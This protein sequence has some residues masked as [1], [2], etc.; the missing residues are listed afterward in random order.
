MRRNLA[1]ALGLA[2]CAA[3]ELTHAA[4]DMTPYNPKERRGPKSSTRE[5]VC[6]NGIWKF[7]PVIEE[8][9]YTC[10]EFPDP[11][12]PPASLKYV[13]L[14][15]PGLWKDRGN[16]FSGCRLPD[17]K[18]LPVEWRKAL[19]AWYHRVFQVP[20][21]WAGRAVIIRFEGIAFYG[22]VFV[23]GKAVGEHLGPGT[24]FELDISALV[25]PGKPNNL[26]VY[27]IDKRKGLHVPKGLSGY[28]SWGVQLW[29]ILPEQWEYRRD[30]AGIWKDVF[31][32]ARDPLFV[33][34]VFAMPSFRK[35][36][37]AG[38]IEV[39]NHG[40]RPC[41]CRV[42]VD[43]LELDGTPV[44]EV[45]S[46]DITVLPG[47]AEVSTLSAPWATPKLWDLDEPNLYVMRARLQDYGPRRN[48]ID[49]KLVRFGFRECWVEKDQIYLNGRIFHPLGDWDTR[50]NVTSPMIA[51][52][53][54]VAL[55]KLESM[56]EDAGFVAPRMT[57]IT[58]Y[59]D[60]YDAADDLGFPIIA[61]GYAGSRIDPVAWDG[62][63]QEWREAIRMR[64]NH[65]SIIIWSCENEGVSHSRA[66]SLY[67]IQRKL[68][69]ILEEMDP[70]RP[71]YHD[72]H[73]SVV[74]GDPGAIYEN[75]D[76]CGTAPIS[77]G[78]YT[79]ATSPMSLW[80]HEFDRWRRRKP[81]V[82]GEAGTFGL[83]DI[84]AYI[85]R[86]YGEEA[87]GQP[88]EEVFDELGGK[89]TK[90][91]IG[92]W[93]SYAVS[94][95]MPLGVYQSYRGIYRHSGR[96]T[97]LKW[98]DL[99]TPGAKPFTTSF[100]LARN[101]YD[102][103]GGSVKVSRYGEWV[104]D[105]FA[106]LL[107][108]LYRDLRHNLRSGEAT[109]AAVYVVN[110]AKTDQTVQLAWSVA[111]VAGGDALAKGE[112]SLLVRQG[113]PAR[114]ELRF[115]AP[116]VKAATRL[117]L[118]VEARADGVTHVAKDDREFSVYPVDPA[119]KLT[120]TLYAYDPENRLTDL[121]ASMKLTAA[122]LSAATFAGA[123][124][125]K[126][127]IIAPY[128]VDKD[129]RPHYGDIDKFL[130]AGG[131]V[132]VLNQ[133]C[134]LPSS[135]SS[136]MHSGSQ[137]HPMFRGL[138]DSRVYFW[139]T[140]GNLVAG[141]GIKLP[142]HGLYVRHLTET[143]HTSLKDPFLFE[144]FKGNGTLVGCNLLLAGAYEKDPEARLMLHNLLRYA[145]GFRRQPRPV[146]FSGTADTASAI[147]KLGVRLTGLALQVAN[148]GQ[149]AVLAGLGATLSKQ[150]IADAAKL[151]SGILLVERTDLVA[152]NRDAV[153]AF[154]A[155]GGA[156]L[157]LAQ[158]DA[159]WQGWGDDAKLALAPAGR[160]ARGGHLHK[161]SDAPMLAGQRSVTAWSE[162]VL[163]LKPSTGWS[164]DF[165]AVG[166]EGPMDRFG[167]AWREQGQGLVIVDQVPHLPVKLRY[168]TNAQGQWLLLTLL[169]N[170]GA[171]LVQPAP[172]EY[173]T[174]FT[175]VKE[176][177]A[178]V[179]ALTEEEKKRFHFLNLKFHMNAC[180]GGEKHSHDVCNAIY[181]KVPLGA[182][183]FGGVP[184]YVVDAD[185]DELLGGDPGATDSCI[186]LRG[187]KMPAL[188][189]ETRE[190]AFE[191][192]RGQA[193]PKTAKRLHFLH[194][195]TWAISS[196][197]AILDPN[198]VAVIYRVRY[199]DGTSVDIEAKNDIHIRDWWIKERNFK[200]LEGGR[201]PKAELGWGERLFSM[202]YA[203][204]TMWVMNWD[205]PHPAREIR[206]LQ[207]IS[208]DKSVPLVFA[209]SV[210][211]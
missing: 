156:L 189:L 112:E 124:E 101:P 57:W 67:M 131:V 12:A 168:G 132:V 178:E 147:A 121:L 90:L 103:E 17:G 134:S 176:S 98:N 1:L 159:A 119:P 139:D 91:V 58:P 87:L 104:R 142:L 47:Q 110:D 66:T 115:Q 48:T 174:A 97:V 102:P 203:L 86:F 137:G 55:A 70:T 52:R 199:R 20:K 93:R 8:A 148:K 164:M 96:A 59:Q 73:A 43:V 11:D 45:G 128:A 206:S 64:R 21:S 117:L 88:T 136:N 78:H 122:P 118:R 60:F 182:W 183:V 72:G 204:G 80:L 201:L 191:G 200:K 31:L 160:A 94:A 28:R 77:G 116:E 84:Q 166:R 130:A 71:Y 36:T 209:V 186:A 26:H 162:K 143:G 161:Q 61:T 16:G 196:K 108:T 187:E 56:R 65:P 19:R 195:S 40:D 42:I 44:L 210:E 35:K 6:L 81:F 190:I 171:D 111:P 41:P 141:C 105:A 10:D 53:Y 172:E 211:E 202:P 34:D 92:A 32:G 152:A 146:Y 151:P 49:E 79:R 39:R 51:Q 29:R 99:E 167:I 109:T 192:E 37:I 163:L 198:H 158:A 75:G 173:M 85:R 127:L 150:T 114:T 54:E 69:Q 157:V 144:M 194:A 13:D 126:A 74:E 14:I 129:L 30:E 106:P 76:L 38:R 135:A 82:Y 46:R 27:V 7:H 208:Q 15:V 177:F 184:F 205:N 4:F 193:F 25:T 123:A 100:P 50:M 179:R 113:V 3:I 63:C 170:L 120:R 89:V 207:V 62:L 125:K 133:D 107:V 5:E 68:D 95:I 140:P 149:A 180:L 22:K 154:V 9:Y 185:T 2:F 18:I 188:P 181:R 83:V 165:Q 138:A 197:G 33:D 155:K 24:P 169:A 175:K 145:D 153:D 23:N